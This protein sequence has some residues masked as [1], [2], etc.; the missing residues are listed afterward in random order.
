MVEAPGEYSWSSYH[1]NALGKSDPLIQPH[2]EYDK[3]GKISEER[4]MAYRLLFNTPI[5]QKILHEVREA[6]NKC[7]TLGDSK[8]KQA[9][10]KQLARNVE[11]SARGGDRKSRK[12]LDATKI[13]PV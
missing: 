13:N 8:F 1:H 4:Q 6:T 5:E 3:L 11:P 10:A 12:Y 9:V 2:L 7:W